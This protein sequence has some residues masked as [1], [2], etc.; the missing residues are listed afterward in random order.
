MAIGVVVGVA[1]ISLV[2]MVVWFS[3]KRK[4]RRTGRNSGYP[5]P[6]PFASSQNSGNACCLFIYLQG[7]ELNAA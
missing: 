1:V 4:K 7:T 5:A 3:Q 6:S 2:L